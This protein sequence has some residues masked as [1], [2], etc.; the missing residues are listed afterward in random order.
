MH[1]RQSPPLLSP[2]APAGLTPI[3]TRRWRRSLL[4][5]LED[6]SREGETFDI[7]QLIS[8]QIGPYWSI[9]IPST[10]PNPLTIVDVKGKA[11]LMSK[12]RPSEYC[13]ERTG[14]KR[15]GVVRSA[16][17]YRRWRKTRPPKSKQSGESEVS[18]AP[19]GSARSRKPDQSSPYLSTCKPAFNYL[20]IVV[21]D[22]QQQRQEV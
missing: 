3:K 18:V 11:K 19:D 20:S 17:E 14:Y 5:S 1:A 6:R 22:G 21:N 8:L 12:C 4:Q 9:I 13:D 7:D 2:S 10:M 15:D 16:A